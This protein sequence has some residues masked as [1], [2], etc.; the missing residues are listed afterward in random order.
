M[1][2]HCHLILQLV[3]T[4]PIWMCVYGVNR[5]LFNKALVASNRKDTRHQSKVSPA[6]QPSIDLGSDEQFHLVH[7]WLSPFNL[8]KL[9][10]KKDTQ[11]DANV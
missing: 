10:E 4:D 3:K 2:N 5:I 11:E 1:W 9:H 7:G 8:M 6:N